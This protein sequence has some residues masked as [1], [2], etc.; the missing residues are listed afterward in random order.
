MGIYDR[1]YYREESGGFQVR[2]PGTIVGWLIVINIVVFLV[3]VLLRTGRYGGP[4]ND[5]LGLQ[6]SDLLKPWLWWRFLTY[7]FCHQSMGHIFGN[8]LGLFF[9]GPPVEQRYGQREFL[10]LYLVLIVVSGVGWAAAQFLPGGYGMGGVVGASGAVT[11]VVVLFALNYPRQTV[12]LMMI[13]PIPAWLL[14][15]L[16]VA[17]D[18]WGSMSHAGQIAYQAHLAGTAMAF[19]YWQG[20]WN[21][22]RLTDKF[23]SGKLFQRRPR[24][25]V[26]RP[27]DDAPEERPDKKEVARAAEMDRILAKLHREGEE[28]LTRK[29]RRTL[30]NESRRLREKRRD[31]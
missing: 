13:L 20:G 17:S 30:Q 19:F 26:H 14:G 10:R 16:V 28:S 3:D 7:G 11:G 1:E 8:M 12:L 24:L 9:L 15:V 5:L 21:F 4:V 31:L 22:T 27:D 2:K 18:V 6:A 29:E 25:R 23:T